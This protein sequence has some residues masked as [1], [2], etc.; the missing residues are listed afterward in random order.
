MRSVVPGHLNEITQS[1]C[2]SLAVG[3]ADKAFFVLE[4]R[5]SPLAAPQ[6]ARRAFCPLGMPN[7]RADNLVERMASGGAA[8]IEYCKPFGS[9]TGLQ[10]G[11]LDRLAQR[12][13][14]A[15]PLAEVAQPLK[16]LPMIGGHDHDRR[17]VA[18]KGRTFKHCQGLVALGLVA[19]L[20][21]IFDEDCGAA[22]GKNEFLDRVGVGPGFLISAERRPKAPAVVGL[23]VT[24]CSSNEN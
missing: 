3:Y 8:Q 6:W 16:D 2:E 15:L 20:T 18:T 4:D 10:E 23:S 7:H 14:T 5:A 19:D 24:S 17:I 13:D 22:V 11:I 12:M 1:L 21:K 9:R